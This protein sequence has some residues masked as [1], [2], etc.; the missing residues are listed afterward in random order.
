MLCY[1]HGIYKI[2]LGMRGPPPTSAHSSLQQQLTHAQTRH[3]FPGQPPH[4]L[5]RLSHPQQIRAVGPQAGP[6]RQ[7]G[8]PFPGP[9]PTSTPGGQMRE[10]HTLLDE[11]LEQ[12]RFFSAIDIFFLLFFHESHSKNFLI[13]S[14][15]ILYTNV[16]SNFHIHYSK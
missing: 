15:F 11:L 6:P 16:E 4:P 2:P 13:P 1:Y 5:P 3:Q 14:T 10:Q 9:A 12:V 7:Q 8:V